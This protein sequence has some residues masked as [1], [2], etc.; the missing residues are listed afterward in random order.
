MSQGSILISIAPSS[1]RDADMAGFEVEL[2]TSPI[3]GLD[4]LF[5]AAYNDADIELDGRESRPVQSPEWN[6]NAL[7]RYQWAM[8]NGKVAIQVDS[9]YRSEQLFALSGLN[10]VNQGGYTVTN[11]SLSYATED[12]KWL[13]SLFVDNIFDEEYRVQQF[14]LTGNLFEGD[15]VMGLIEEYYGRPQWWGFSATV[16]F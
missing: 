3:D 5:G 11:A 7:V 13:F 15:G 12:E 10:S 9:D 6:I 14:D 1:N 4:I 16:N 8:A 2:Q